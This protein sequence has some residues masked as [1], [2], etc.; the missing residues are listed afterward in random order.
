MSG[1]LDSMLHPIRTV[2]ENFS[3]EA[4]E[5]KQDLLFENN[6]KEAAE[7]LCN[8]DGLVT[9]DLDKEL[10]TL[11][12]YNNEVTG[13]KVDKKLKTFITNNKNAIEEAKSKIESLKDDYISKSK[14]IQN[15][16]KYLR[17]YKRNIIGCKKAVRKQKKEI[18]NE[19]TPLEY[20]LGYGKGKGSKSEL[21]RAKESVKKAI[22]EKEKARYKLNTLTSDLSNIK[23]KIKEQKE[24]ISKINNKLNNYKKLFKSQTDIANN[25]IVIGT[26]AKQAGFMDWANPECEAFL[27][28]NK[29]TMQK[30]LFKNTPE[31]K[32]LSYALNNL[33]KAKKDLEKT[34]DGKDL[35]A[36]LHNIEKTPEFFIKNKELINKNRHTLKKS[37]EG[38]AL[39]TALDNLEKKPDVLEK[40]KNSK[41]L[42]AALMSLQKKDPNFFKQHK[43]TIEKNRA[44][45]ESSEEGKTLLAALDNLENNINVLEQNDEGKDLLNVLLNFSTEKD[46][47]LSLA[48]PLSADSNEQVQNTEHA[49]D[50]LNSLN[51]EYSR[52]KKGDKHIELSR[53]CQNKDGRPLLKTIKHTAQKRLN[54]FLEKQMALEN[55]EL[56]VDDTLIQSTDEGR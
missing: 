5:Y 48:N 17:T 29:R 44:F 40:S 18:F 14:S 42:Y 35:L 53:A 49:I 46:L 52:S 16:N 8:T 9:M 13:I 10:A 22:A 47:T 19:V 15:Q 1:F 3:E 30:S 27:E 36:A 20:F 50:I 41:E 34:Q 11:E 51:L 32:S 33:G 26:M 31:G 25:H 7:A 2:K 55:G 6:A 23:K 28:K 45:L 39:L 38:K 4:I 24:V 12:Y 56:V 37:K 54:K 21:K 43:N